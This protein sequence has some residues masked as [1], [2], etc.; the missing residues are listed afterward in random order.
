[1]DLQDNTI[2]S[3]LLLP[4]R[5]RLEVMTYV[6]MTGQG[7]TVTLSST[8]NVGCVRSIKLPEW[9]QE[10]IDASCLDTT[11]FKRYIAGDL[12]D[13]GQVEITAVFEN[14]IPLPGV[15]ED[16]TVTFPIGT[17]GNTQA[18]TLTGSGFVMSVSA[19]SLE[20]DS[21]LEISLTFCFDGAT[22][23]AYAPEAA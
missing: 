7:A 15:D 4:L 12:T 21:L 22:G 1:M 18:G 9:A 20:M 5:E 6:G 23:P 19:P 2:L 10:K 17:S 16:I 11:G 3:D 13:P 14:A 8:G